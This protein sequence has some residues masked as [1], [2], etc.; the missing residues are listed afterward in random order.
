[1]CRPTVLPGARLRPPRWCG[2]AI[3]IGV[4][5]LASSS[6]TSIAPSGTFMRTF[7]GTMSSPARSATRRFSGRTDSSTRLP[8]AADK[9]IGTT[10]RVPQSSATSSPAS[11]RCSAVPGSR[12]V[13]P[14][15][16]LTNSEPGRS[17][18]S[19]AVPACST[20]PSRSTTMRSAIDNA[21]SWS[22]VTRIEVMP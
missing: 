10:S 14:R 13:W 17:Y 5:Q 19:D 4:P 2:R 6:V 16:R 21:S 1:M 22:C 8:W 7:A 3:F 12:L 15:N 9:P 20:A 18:S 11:S